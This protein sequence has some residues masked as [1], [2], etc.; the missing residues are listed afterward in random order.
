VVSLSR[1][2]AENWCRRQ[3]IPLGCGPKPPT[4]HNS[5]PIPVD[6][7]QRIALV[8]EQMAAFEDG[9]EV[10]VWIT[11]WGVWPSAERPHLFDRLRA[12]YGEHR[13]LI[14][15]PAYLF[16]PSEFEDI[17]SFVTLGVLFLWDVNVIGAGSRRMLLYSHDEMV[18]VVG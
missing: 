17:L 1:L 4:D 2:E 16:L 13:P 12:S 18:D 6:T 8:R 9:R 11:K 14:E 15:I 5:V 3:G 10:L 7:G